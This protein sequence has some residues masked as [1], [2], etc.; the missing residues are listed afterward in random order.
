MVRRGGEAEETPEIVWQELAPGLWEARL[1]E[2]TG[3]TV[4]AGYIARSSDSDPW[5]GY[6]GVSFDF[7]A[8]GERAEVRR[9]VE[10][11]ARRVWAAQRQATA[12][13]STARDATDVTDRPDE[14][15]HR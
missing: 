6:L 5:R 11:T 14:D 1:V 9:A 8:S 2:P 4:Y 3:L 15:G 10:K 7:V 13:A 12:R